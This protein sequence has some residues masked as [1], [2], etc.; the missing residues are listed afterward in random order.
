MRGVDNFENVVESEF[1]LK[2]G[3]S[4]LD[5]DEKDGQ[6]HAVQNWKDEI[7][8]SYSNSTCDHISNDDNGGQEDG[9]QSQDLSEK[10][11]FKDKYAPQFFAALA[12]N[13]YA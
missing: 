3:I 1:E 12:G 11:Q 8:G 9:S 2:V 10:S 13:T 6:D 7:N 4:S 5:G